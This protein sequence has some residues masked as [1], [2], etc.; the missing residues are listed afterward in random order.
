[1]TEQLEFSLKVILPCGTRFGRGKAE[2][3]QHIDAL[4]SIS[5]AAKAMGMSYPRASRLAGEINTMF[6][7]QLIETFQG[8]AARGG[9]RLTETGHKIL[10][11]YVAWTHNII[12]NSSELTAHF[13]TANSPSDP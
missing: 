9:A 11:S 2:L 1:M 13:L 4:G 3:M 10:K 12:E 5:A 7:A 8:G 6:G